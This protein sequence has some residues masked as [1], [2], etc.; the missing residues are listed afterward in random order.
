MTTGELEVA[1]SM[2]LWTGS[3]LPNYYR[4]LFTAQA[5]SNHPTAHAIKHLAN[6][7][8]IAWSNP[9]RV[10]EYAGRGVIAEVNGD[11]LC[12]GRENWFAEVGIPIDTSNEKLNC[13]D[14]SSEMSIS[15]ISKNNKVLG[16]VGFRDSIR[17]NAKEVIHEL[18]ELGIQSCTMITG[19][20][21]SVANSVAN[22]VGINHVK[23]GCLPEA[24]VEHVKKLKEST[25]IVA[26]VG[27]GVNDAPALA[28]GDIGIAMGALGNGTAV[29]SASVALMNNDLGKVPFLIALS[30]KTR[31]IIHINIVFAGILILAGVVFFTFGDQLISAPAEHLN[32]KPSM[33]KSFIASSV[34][35][36]GTLAVFF[37]SARL[38]GFGET[39]KP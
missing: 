8:N 3:N 38:I 32:I 37:N 35:I 22:Q 5:Q 13:H 24:K 15:H 2:P 10:T 12:V 36:G 23:A 7:S 14:F 39:L 6:Q 33:F 9:S 25:T 11:T 29:N 31:S 21:P 34:Q 28:T 27:D 18:S 26:V 16:W 20:N 30:R 17:N 19:D 4:P 1:P